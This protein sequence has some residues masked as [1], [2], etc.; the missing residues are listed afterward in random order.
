MKFI[1]IALAASLVGCGS[2]SERLNGVPQTIKIVSALPRKANKAETDAIVN[3]IRMALDD[4]KWRVG[5]FTLVFEDVD[6]ADSR[7]RRHV[8]ET[9]EKI[10]NDEDV[11]ACIGT[12][13]SDASRVFM[14]VLNRADL[15]MITPVSTWP[16]LTKPGAALAGEPGIHRPTG[17]VNFFRVM[18]TDDLQGTA[19]AEWSKQLGATRV[20][21]LHDNEPLG[22]AV[23]EQYRD[24]AATIGLD[25]VGF[26]AINPKQAEFKSLMDRVKDRSPDLI[27]FGGTT[28]TKGGQI[29]K[30]IL[31]AG[32]S[33]V[34]FMVYNGCFDDGFIKSAGPKVLN[35]RTYITVVGIPHDRRTGKGKDFV[36]RYMARHGAEPRW[37][38]IRGFEA[39]NVILEAIRRAKRKD[40]NAIR[41]ACLGIR[42]FDGALGKWSFDSNGDIT[43]RTISGRIVRDGKFEF[44][45]I[46]GSGE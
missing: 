46:L 39:A 26:E 40:R 6:T 17:R 38:G 11:M 13:Y 27:Y 34:K 44:L 41:E 29:A 45:T 25:L 31:A 10:V 20:Y 12:Y 18:P 43:L 5:D 23:A 21:V 4:A 14:P 30:D 36:D 24:R 2:P 28:Q 22:K 8:Q 9:A 33:R 42:D 3:G 15:V 16:G 7:G 1:S 35:D 37:Y 32:M 19:G